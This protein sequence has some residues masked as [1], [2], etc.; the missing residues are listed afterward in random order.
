MGAGV[1]HYFEDGTEYTGPTHKD[2]KGRLMSGKTHNSSSK[3]LFHKKP[4]KT[5]NKK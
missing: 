1:K 4:A 3:F 5:K 2:G